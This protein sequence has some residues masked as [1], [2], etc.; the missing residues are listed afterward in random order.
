MLSKDATSRPINRE[1]NKVK[2][3]NYISSLH[4]IYLVTDPPSKNIKLLLWSYTKEV[5][6]FNEP[7]YLKQPTCT[8][9]RAQSC[10]RSA[11][12]VTD[13]YRISCRHVSGW[14]ELQGKRERERKWTK[15]DKVRRLKMSSLLPLA[16]PCPKCRH[17]VVQW[18]QGKLVHSLRNIKIYSRNE[19]PSNKKRG[20]WMI[21]P[22]CLHVTPQQKLDQMIMCLCGVRYQEVHK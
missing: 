3:K 4:H 10:Y 20:N 17:P 18:M 13:R 9:Q 8:L 11:N 1:K 7:L 19:F 6:C 5:Y 2:K 16:P 12:M 22:Q 14:E 21:T 15:K